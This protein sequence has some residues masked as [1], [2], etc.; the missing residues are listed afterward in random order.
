LLIVSEHAIIQIKKLIV[1][2]CKLEKEDAAS[3]ASPPEIKIEIDGPM[4]IQMA[5]GFI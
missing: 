1:F 5:P 3:R 4:K 2:K